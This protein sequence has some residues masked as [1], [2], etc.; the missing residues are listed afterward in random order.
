MSN[1]MDFKYVLQDFSNVYI[2]MRLTYS[3]LERQDDTPQKL[4]AAVFQYLQQET[5]DEER[6][7]DHIYRMRDDSVSYRVFSQLK[8][9]LKIQYPEQVTDKQGR[10]KTRYRVKSYTIPD[11]VKDEALKAEITPEQIT[12]YVFKKRYLMSLTV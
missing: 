12:E 10:I 6:L 9:E 4:R 11:F 5:G 8:G 1:E 7:C 3:E 2:G